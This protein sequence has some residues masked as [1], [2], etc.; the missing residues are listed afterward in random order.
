MT[1]DLLWPTSRSPRD[2]TTIE[3]IPLEQRGLPACT[4]DV[5]LRA[6]RLWPDRTAITV[7]AD[8]TDFERSARRTFAE[9]AADVTRA[10]RV[11]RHFGIGRHDGC[12]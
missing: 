5:V 3:Q 10:A 6:G 2:L 11:L 4:Y 12:C 9:L 1:P 7:L 8:G